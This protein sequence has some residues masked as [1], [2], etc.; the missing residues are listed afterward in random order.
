MYPPRSGKIV[1]GQSFGTRRHPQVALR[2]NLN[3]VRV[4]DTK[5][6]GCAQAAKWRPCRACYSGSVWDRATQ[7]RAN[8]HRVV[9][10]ALGQR[11]CA[12]KRAIPW[13]M[14]E[15]F[16]VEP[17]KLMRFLGAK[18]VL[19]PRR[20]GTRGGHGDQ[21]GRTRR[22]PRLVPDTSGRKR[23]QYRFPFARHRARNHCRFKG[24]KLDNG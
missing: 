5:S 21:G 13:T 6:S 18:V 3:A 4:S 24:E 15:Q 20:S 10:P 2:G 8:R 14:A 1:R 22:C 11:W 7:A 23:S 19:T 9:T 12:G 16:S 17:R